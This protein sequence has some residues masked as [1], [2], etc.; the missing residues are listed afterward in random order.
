MERGTES[1]LDV[2]SELKNA[3]R[4]GDARAQYTL[5]EIEFN[6]GNKTEALT[7]LKKS[8]LQHS[9]DACFTMA[10]FQIAG[11]SVPYDAVGARTNLTTA[12]GQGHV[13]AQ[14]LL[15]QM[16]RTGYGGDKSTKLANDILRRLAVK[17]HPIALCGIAMLLHVRKQMSTSVEILLERAALEGSHIAAYIQAEK[18]RDAAL[19]GDVAAR[20]D[21]IKYLFVS[22]RAGNKLAAAELAEYDKSI[23]QEILNRASFSPH[24]DLDVNFEDVQE[25]LEQEAEYNFDH[26]EIL[27][28]ENNILIYRK[29]LTPLECSYIKA[30]AAPTIRPSS[31]I[32]PQ[33]GK[34]IKNEI[35]TSSSSNFDPV[36]RD[37][38][39]FA[40]DQRIAAAT[41]TD[42][43]QGE[44]LN[45]LYYRTGEEYKF[46][47]DYL[48]E[49]T[50]EELDLLEDGGQRK[51]TFLISMNE[52]YSGGETYFPRLN[53]TYRGQLGDA[54]MFRNLD[55]DGRPNS[56]MLHAGM[57]ISRG[58]KWVASKWIREGEF[59]FGKPTAI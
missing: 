49:G 13:D 53:L 56:L 51:Y 35:R 39:I 41:G 29:F 12:A 9:P 42:V 20:E 32:N 26:P 3:A 15:S 4:R 25:I 19:S 36:S 54:L 38:F 34:L 2:D 22:A 30:A 16:L 8:A 21:R 17:N 57:P 37:S 14:L 24:T 6:R 50:K 23:V 46:H 33:T 43:E 5:S 44:P 59:S 27:S 47:Y 7:W 40:V 58:L 48:P 11:V 10:T 31:T 1:V 52:E 45:V 55:D 28:S 18:R